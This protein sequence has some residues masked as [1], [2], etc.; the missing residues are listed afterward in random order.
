MSRAAL[1]LVQ[2]AALSTG[3]P[4]LRSE[5]VTMAIN[6]RNGLRPLDALS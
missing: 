2:D 1:F 3:I 5:K 4:L 6:Q